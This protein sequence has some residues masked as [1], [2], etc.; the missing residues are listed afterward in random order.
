[1]I[2]FWCKLSLLYY[3][4]SII[5]FSYKYQLWVRIHCCLYI[6]IYRNLNFEQNCVNSKRIILKPK[7][8]EK[9]WRLQEFNISIAWVSH[10]SIFQMK[11]LSPHYFALTLPVIQNMHKYSPV[12]TS[13]YNKS[14]PLTATSFY[15]EG[16]LSLHIIGPFAS[17]RKNW[18]GK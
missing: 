15:F 5:I 18:A 4:W 13:N 7:K 14:L 10:V 3:S 2:W 12:N 11:R 9:L 6:V 8:I 16:L 17:L 1:M